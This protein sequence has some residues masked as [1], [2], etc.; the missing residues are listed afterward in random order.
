M[1][2]PEFKHRYRNQEVVKSSAL[3]TKGHENYRL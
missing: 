2:K 3:N 1:I